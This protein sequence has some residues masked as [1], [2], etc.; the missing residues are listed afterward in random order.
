MIAQTIL[1]EDYKIECKIIHEFNEVFPLI[2]RNV[3]VYPA[4]FARFWE[5][6]PSTTWMWSHQMFRR[7][8]ELWPGTGEGVGYG[9]CSHLPTQLSKKN[10]WRVAY[11]SG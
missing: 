9:A 1:L 3:M 8:E 6:D 11:K 7:T 10:E 4:R 2:T 5:S